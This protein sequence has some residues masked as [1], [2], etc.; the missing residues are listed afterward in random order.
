MSLTPCILEQHWFNRVNFERINLNHC[1]RWKAKRLQLYE[2]DLT[3][4]LNSLILLSFFE[5]YH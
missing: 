2:T 3:L 4:C 1:S 5:K